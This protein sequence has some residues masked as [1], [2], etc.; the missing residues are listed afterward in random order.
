ME[1][2]IQITVRILMTDDAIYS[3]ESFAVGCERCSSWKDG[4]EEDL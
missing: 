1:I 2:P 3:Y 4:I